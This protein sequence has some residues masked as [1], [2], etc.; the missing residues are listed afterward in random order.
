[1]GKCKSGLN[2]LTGNPTE[3]RFLGSSKRKWEGVEVMSVNII[4]GFSSRGRNN[5]RALVITALNFQIS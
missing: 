3:E 4:G 2:V 1:M 5:W